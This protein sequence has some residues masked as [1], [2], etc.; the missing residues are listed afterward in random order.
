MHAGP[1]I[2]IN[3]YELHVRDPD[4]HDLLYAGPRPGPRRP[5]KGAWSVTM[6]ANGASGFGTVPH[7]L[8][9]LRRAALNPFFGKQA[10][11]RRVEPLVREL[12]TQM[13]ARFEAL[14]GGTGG[15]GAGAGA[16]TP[17]DVMRLYAALTT[18]VIT[19][20]AFAASYGCVGDPGR[21]SEWPRAMVEGAKSCHLNK[22]SP[23]LVPLT[24]DVGGM[25]RGLSAVWSVLG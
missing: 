10:V 24:W 21:R 12:V 5:D 4:F 19:R 13:W 3:P 23:W 25:K 11:A 7:D 22:Q 1:I 8:H 15:A 6:F 9:R 20:Y 17:L 14:K 16:G 2:R 18:D